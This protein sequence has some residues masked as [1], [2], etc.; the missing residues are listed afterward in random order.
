MESVLFDLHVAV[1]MTVLLAI[2]FLLN[3]LVP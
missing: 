3:R 2:F 1:G